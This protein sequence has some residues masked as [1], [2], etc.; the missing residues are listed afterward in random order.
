MDTSG[1]QGTTDIQYQVAV[2][3]QYKKLLEL[4][5][6]MIVKLIESAHVPGP[7]ENISL[8]GI[9]AGIDIRV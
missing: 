2:V 3:S 8:P 4:K 1:V 7:S 6:A 9:G 5:G